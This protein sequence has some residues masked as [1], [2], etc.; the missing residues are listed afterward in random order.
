MRRRRPCAFGC[1]WRNPVSWL[2]T[3]Q[4]GPRVIFSLFRR[5][6]RRDAIASALRAR[7][8]GLARARALFRARDPRHAGGALRGPLPPRDPG[9]ARACAGSRTRPRRSPRTSRT[10]SSATSTPRLREMGVGD[11]VVPK[12]MKTPGQRLLRPGARLRRPAR[13]GRRSRPRRGARPQRRRWRRARRGPLARYVI[14]ADRRIRQA[15]LDAV[16]ARGFD[17]ACRAGS[18]SW[19]RH[20]DSPMPSAP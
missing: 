16:L 1:R 2:L 20:D 13:R 6:P 18:P 10:P 19:R 14:A 5:D 7:R 17:F 11:T 12:R 9:P 15:D 3:R 8:D 4:E